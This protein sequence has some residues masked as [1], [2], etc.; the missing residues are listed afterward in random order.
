MLQSM[1]LKT[2]STKQAAR[3]VGILWVTLL[4]WISSGKFKPSRSMRLNGNRVWLWTASDVKRLRK[5]K[6]AHYWE[7]RGAWKSAKKGV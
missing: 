5:Y 7:G 6:N 3:L 4:R 1:A 2:Y